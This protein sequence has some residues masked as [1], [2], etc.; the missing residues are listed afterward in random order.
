M[1]FFMLA[2]PVRTYT[3]KGSTSE[4]R[5]EIRLGSPASA[6]N[7]TSFLSQNFISDE[8]HPQEPQRVYKITKDE[9]KDIIEEIYRLWGDDKAHIAVAVFM[10]ESGLDPTQINHNDA[11]ITGKASWG[12]AQLN[13]PY[14]EGWNDYKLNLKRAYEEFYV[15]R[16]FQPWSCYSQGLYLKYL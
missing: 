11:L 1:L 9:Q 7:D 4:T 2:F 13:V 12:I 8:F 10:C 15:K 3:V 6:Y 16:G 5:Q 14:F